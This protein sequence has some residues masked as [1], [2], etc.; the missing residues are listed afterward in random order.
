MLSF[1]LSV[2]AWQL[3]LQD[4]LYILWAAWKYIGVEIAW[5]L[6]TG[7]SMIT[8]QI[9]YKATLWVTASIVFCYNEGS[10]NKRRGSTL[11]IT[12]VKWN[13]R[14]KA[15]TH[16]MLGGKIAYFLII[17][18]PLLERVRFCV[19]TLSHPLRKTKRLAR[20]VQ[21]RGWSCGLLDCG[22][23]KMS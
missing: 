5:L 12:E 18:D 11:H 19:L 15:Q 1:Q 20:R 16:V 7:T 22:L 10:G 6:P 9:V 3:Q 23:L 2:V 21:A 13:S 8:G 17:F 4:L 14:W